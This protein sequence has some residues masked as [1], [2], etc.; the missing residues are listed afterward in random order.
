M[1]IAF[2]SIPIKLI[3]LVIYT[4]LFNIKSIIESWGPNYKLKIVKFTEGQICTET[5]L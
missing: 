2:Y 5:L 4:D 3:S 1:K